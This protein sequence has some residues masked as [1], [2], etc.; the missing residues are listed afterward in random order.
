[1]LSEAGVDALFFDVTN[2]VTYRSAY[3][4]ICK[5]ALQM[6]REGN[7]TPQFAFVTNGRRSE[8]VTKLYQEFYQPKRYAD[9]WFKW[10]GKPLILGDP[11]TP[12]ASD[13][14]PAQMAQFDDEYLPS[15]VGSWKKGD[16]LPEEIKNFFSWRQSWA[17][18]APTGW[19]GDG[20]NKWP[21]LDNTPQTPGL[22]GAGQVEEIVV[23]PA[24]HPTTNKGRSYSNGV[25]PPTNQFGLASDTDKGIYFAEQWKRALEVDAPLLWITQWNEWTAMRLVATD[26]NRPALLGRRVNPGESYFVDLYNREFSRDIEPMKGGW[27]DNYYMQM[28][29]GIRRFKGVRP[30]PTDGA[31]RTLALGDW[32]GWDKI[33]MEYRDTIGDNGTRDWPGWGGNRYIN[34]SGRND[35]VR[36]KVAV[37]RNDVHFYVQTH[38]A[39]RWALDAAAH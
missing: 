17:W 14:N 36:A 1:M 37:S 6:R 34:A 5:V 27:G 23:S 30:T 24:Q 39:R 28:F 10:Q 32:A 12:Y 22:D 15:P 35:I 9:L 26:T 2:S 3:I 33:E 7:K 38:A 21:W 29:D 19:Y 13:Y 18:T 25:E 31:L 11:N 8:T 4:A 20:K 16:A